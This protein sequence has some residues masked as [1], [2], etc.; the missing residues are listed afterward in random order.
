MNFGLELEVRKLSV[1]AKGCSS[2]SVARRAAHSPGAGFPRQRTK[3]AVIS[4]DT[5]GREVP[6]QKGI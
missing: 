2:P 1:A 5:A 6:G 3:V 4:V